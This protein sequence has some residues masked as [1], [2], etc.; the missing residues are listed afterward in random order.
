MGV[1]VWSKRLA[2]GKVIVK[3]LLGSPSRCDGA[4]QGGQSPCGCAQ[5][6]VCMEEECRARPPVEGW[7]LAVEA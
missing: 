4:R 3:R 7:R 1:R 2:A 5:Q 6:I